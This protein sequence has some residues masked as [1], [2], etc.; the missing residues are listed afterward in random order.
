VRVSL[1]RHETNLGPAAARNT[2]IRNAQGEFVAFLDSDD[3][4]KPDKLEK[5]LAFMHQHGLDF[6]C[7]G[8]EVIDPGATYAR[9]AWRPYPETLNLDHFVWGCFVAPG[10]TFVARRT[11]LDS[12]GGYDTRFARFEDWDLMLR[13]AEANVKGIG[14][15]NE[16]LATIHFSGKPE[17]DKVFLSLQTLQQIY[18]EGLNHK[19]PK[20]AQTL[21]SGLAF[22]RAAAHAAGGSWAASARELA[23]CFFLVPRRNWPLRVIL[24]GKLQG[25]LRA[26]RS[27]I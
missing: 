2:G 24:G 9:P 15:L 3:T 27:K 16:P 22:H 21:R 13:L 1:I 25:K 20:L 7:S 18:L 26:D 10:S 11:L 17:R 23:R 8:F 4:W 6:C 12:I 19:N 14:F 5:Q